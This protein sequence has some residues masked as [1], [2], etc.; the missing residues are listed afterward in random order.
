MSWGRTIGVLAGVL[1][2]LSCTAD[3]PSEL[4]GPQATVV[5]GGY[6]LVE[7]RL[8]LELGDLQASNVIGLEG[9]TVHLLGHKI[10]VP[11]GAVNQPA[12]FTIRVVT[13]GYVEVDLTALGGPGGLIDIGANGFAVPVKLTLT[14]ARASNVS[15]PARLVVLRKLGAGYF[16]A[17]EVMPSTVNPGSKTVEA[18]LDHF[19]SYVMAEG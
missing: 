14:Y 16:G 17:Y 10:Y 6:R 9:G 3:R 11:L 13:N 18:E 7:E 4:S 12:L 5:A 1:G 8:G 19:S 2:L 15:S